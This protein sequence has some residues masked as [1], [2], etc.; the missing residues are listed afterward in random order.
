MA[1]DTLERLSR[2]FDLDP[3]AAA[4]AARAP[5][6]ESAAPWYLRAATAFG[7]WGTAAAM[8]LAAGI[9]LAEIIADAGL[10]RAA[11]VC[12]V[13][14]VAAAAAGHRRSTR[15]FASELAVATALAGQGLV[16]GG[17]AGE[18][19]SVS[20]A[21]AAGCVLAAAT[22][23]A[24]RDLEHQFLSCA[25]AV[26][27]T[28][29]ALVVNEQPQSAGILAA[30][31]LPAAI[32][33][34]VRP[35]AK[36]DLRGLAW[37]LLLV[38]LAAQALPD[39]DTPNPDGPDLEAIGGDLL[40]RIAYAAALAGAVALLWRHSASGRRRIVAAGLVAVLLGAVAAPGILGS[41]LLL[42]LAYL[43]GSRVLAVLGV[44]AHVGF[45]SQFYYDLDLTLLEKSGMLTAA[46]LLLLAL[47]WTWMRQ[48]P[49][50]AGDA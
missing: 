30:V 23:A 8:I 42:T 38:P 37:A 49:G 29:A 9:V 28:M 32:G 7:A 50:E 27:L 20:V 39:L 21:A 17:L 15:P 10:P 16:A 44:V 25:L 33:L 36:A 48:R 4:L 19:E 46:G 45:V 13:V 31:T 47:W 12:G 5:G 1:D 26:G 41:M 22:T 40:A 3:A 24:I 18:F 35:P 2:R 34:L 11:I 14:L 6:G 43:L